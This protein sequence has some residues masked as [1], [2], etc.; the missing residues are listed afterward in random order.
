VG[1][2]EIGG[3]KRNLQNAGY[4]FHGLNSWTCIGLV[5]WVGIGLVKTEFLKQR[6]PY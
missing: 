2:K 3:G 6:I 4:L 5:Y 1:E